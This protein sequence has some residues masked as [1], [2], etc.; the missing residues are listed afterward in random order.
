[1]NSRTIGGIL[2]VS[3]TTIGAGMLALPVLTG[4]AGFL[5]SS[6]LFVVYW[7][8]SVFTALLMLEVNLWFPG[9]VNLISMARRTLGMW[10]EVTAWVVYLLLLYSLTAAYLAGSG[11]LLEDALKSIFNYSMPGWMEPLPVLIIFGSFVY[12]GTRCVDYLN[13]FLILGVVFAYIGLLAIASPHINM[14]LL[15]HRQ[16]GLLWIAIPV[17][18]TSFGFHIIIPS[19]KTYLKDD[20]RSLKKVILVGSAIPLI[21]YISWEVVI[22][23]I[24][25][26][27]GSTG[28]E[29]A[30]VNG[31]NAT[32]PLT[33]LLENPYIS[34][35]ARLFAFFAIIT[36]FLGV[37][38]SLSDFLAD[39]LKIK[40]TQMGRILVI[41]LT[42]IPPLLF[43][44]VYPRGF[45]MALQYAGAFVAI[46]LGILPILMAWRGRRDYSKDAVYQAI[47]GPVL[48]SAVIVFFVGVIGVVLLPVWHRLPPS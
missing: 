10:G 26:V 18:V 15:S 23:G 30:L 43:V 39:G 46:L 2:L 24:V 31:D 27:G 17:I 3:G 13:R 41:C 34:V 7:L 14:E 28:L 29:Q 4:N 9:E 25:P 38:L 35:F 19:L 1:M 33:A 11:P 40:K 45:I 48:F 5:W 36:S 21:V 8:I 20:V 6:A 44:W 32:R 47:G 22:L 37:S 42:F 16:P 12:H